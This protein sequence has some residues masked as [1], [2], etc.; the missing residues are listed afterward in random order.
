MSFNDIKKNKILSENLEFTVSY[1]PAPQVQGVLSVRCLNLS[2]L[3]EFHTFAGVF[4]VLT[5]K[6]MV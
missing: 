2:R 5:W 3:A 1:F 6:E 4:L